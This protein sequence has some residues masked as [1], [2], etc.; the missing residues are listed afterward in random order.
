MSKAE[1][2]QAIIT[3]Q[4]H[5]AKFQPKPPRGPV[6]IKAPV[7]NHETSTRYILID[8][9]LRALGWDLSNPAECV[10][11]HVVDRRGNY[12]AT[13][14]DYV[15]MCPTDQPAVVIE[16]K[17]IDV[18]SDDE[19]ALDQMERYLQDIP[20]AMIAVLTNGQ[21]W[22]IAKREGNGWERVG[23]LPLGLHYENISQNA[24][25]LWEALSKEAVEQECA[26]RSNS[27]G[28]AVRNRD[29]RGRRRQGARP[30]PMNQGRN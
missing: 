17:R 18:E 16:A 13:R 12:P 1:V 23:N 7:N 10:V 11:E 14:V 27:F 2:E 26:K 20:T 3:A 15:L 6:N 5:V 19:R 24:Q 22:E 25:R 28:A 29:G 4:K 30:G 9:I 21:Y 8:P